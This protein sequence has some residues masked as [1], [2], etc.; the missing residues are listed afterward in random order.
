[1]DPAV[2]PDFLTVEEA[3]R[4][5]RIG[6]TTAYQQAHRWLDGGNDGLPV[7]WVGGSLRSPRDQFE[8][9][10]K[11]RITAIPPPEPRRRRGADKAEEQARPV[12]DIPRSKPSRRRKGDGTAQD[13]LPFAG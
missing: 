5:L 2:I 9:H 1:M 13:G 7:E 11:V 10:Y 3:A 4:V 6:R 8:Q 12:Q